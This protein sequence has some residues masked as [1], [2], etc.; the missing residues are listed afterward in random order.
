MKNIAE[1]TQILAQYF[2]IVE[3]KENL[4]AK[5][6]KLVNSEQKEEVKVKETQK[7]PLLLVGKKYNIQAKILSKQKTC[8]EDI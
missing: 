4:E 7:S 6:T 1:L 5:I 3:S 2:F 8:L